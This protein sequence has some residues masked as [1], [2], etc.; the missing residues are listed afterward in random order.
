[1][2]NGSESAVVAVSV[3]GSGEGTEAAGG[4]ALLVGVG[5]GIA[6]AATEFLLGVTMVGKT[7]PFSIPAAKRINS[8]DAKMAP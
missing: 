2:T 3:D 4:E 7:E 6:A 8:K 1:L 5:D